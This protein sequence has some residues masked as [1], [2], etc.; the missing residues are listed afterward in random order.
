[1]TYSGDH[2]DSVTDASSDA[3]SNS[4]VIANGTIAGPQQLQ[5][6]QTLQGGGSTIQMR[7]QRSGSIAS[8][9]APGAAAVLNDPGDAANLTPGGNNTHIAG[10]E[11]IGTGVPAHLDN[12]GIDILFN[13]ANIFI[14]QVTV[15]DGA[16]AGIEFAAFNSVSILNSHIGG[17]GPSILFENGNTVFISGTTM[18]STVGSG[19]NFTH[20]NNITLANS[21][22]TGTFGQFAI[23]GGDDNVLAGAG[24]SAAGATFPGLCSLGLDTV[25]FFAFK[26][27]GSGNAGT[28]P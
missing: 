20:N 27:N 5:G 7:G 10:L 1:V 24:N 19:L 3:G 14:N 9:T 22:F 12:V 8:F 25:G 2:G 23:D 15:S 16:Q 17:R 6:D 21:R 11:I 4:L 26:D 18:H 28:C 13:Q